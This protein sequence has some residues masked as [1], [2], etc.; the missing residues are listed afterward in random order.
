VDAGLL[1]TTL[2]EELGAITAA[3]LRKAHALVESGR[4]IGKTVLTGF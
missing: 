2:R 4:S 3:I 1:R